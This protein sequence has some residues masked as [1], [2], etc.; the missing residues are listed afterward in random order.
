MFN[1]LKDLKENEC[2]QSHDSVCLA[3]IHLLNPPY[4]NGIN[5]KN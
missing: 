3:K 2:H 1:H 4:T 5:R